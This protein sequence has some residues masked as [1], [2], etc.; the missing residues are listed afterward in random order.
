V[1]YGATH[2]LTR[3]SKLA[4][5][6]VGFADGY[7]LRLSNNAFAAFQQLKAPI[8]GRISMD[9]TVV[10]VTDIPES[11]CYVGG[12]AELVNQDITL[13]TLAHSTGIHSRAL[14]TGFTS[15]VTRIHL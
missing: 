2:T 6:G 11:L 15:R 8:I 7:D 14:S 1:G 12:W 4:T 9:Y 13:D 3:N 10:D 5:I